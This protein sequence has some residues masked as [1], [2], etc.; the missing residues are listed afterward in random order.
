MTKT[1]SKHNTN[2]GDAQINVINHLESHAE[3]LE[4]HDIKLWTILVV[5]IILL[6]LTLKKRYDDHDRKRQLKLAK[7]IASI[8]NI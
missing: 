1:V 2:T 7:S 6:I 5:V 8:Q 4:T 3:L